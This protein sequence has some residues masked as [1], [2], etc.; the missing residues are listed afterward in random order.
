MKLKNLVVC[1]GGNSSH[2]LIPFL[3]DSIFNVDVFTSRPEK[4]SDVIT[5]EWQDGSGSIL[6]T[7]CGK[8]RKASNDPSELFPEA[9]YVVFCMPVHQYRIALHRIAP[10]LNRSKNVVLCTL[11]GQGGWNWMVDEIKNQYS[12]SNLITFA[13][14]LIPWICRIK[15]YGKSGVVYGVSKQANF[16]AAYPNQ[17]FEQISKELIQPICS[18]DI[19]QERVEQ[20]PN[21]LSLTLSA[22]NQII[23]TSRCLGLYK[24][25]GKEWGTKDEVP[26]FYKDWDGVSSEILEAIDREY[27]FIRN[28]FKAD[29]PE[30]DFSYMRDYMELEKFGY[31]SE[32]TDIKSSFTEFGTLD[33]I[34][35]P[36]VKNVNAK[37]EIDRSHRFFLDDIF[38]GNCIAKWMAEQFCIET[39]TIDE[40]LSWAQ[41]MRQEEIIRNHKLIL[42]SQD[43]CVPF[44]TGIPTVYG[45]DNI[46][47][48]LD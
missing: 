36:V 1:G 6:D 23:H 31:D 48:C 26:W 15:E 25:Y 17:A 28:R 37:W 30:I 38:Y 9:D 19:V 44:K 35:T 41:E 29:F 34:Q 14:G 2:V 39:P 27:T 12:L 11:Y 42:D 33:A 46:N 10:Y 13:F 20:S 40:I 24:V 43:L 45:F 8:I 47:D 32:I 4:W 22:D 7:T 18:N 21:F 16:A 5:L 3:N